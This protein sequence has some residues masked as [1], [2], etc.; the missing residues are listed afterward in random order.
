MVTWNDW[1]SLFCNYRRNCFLVCV[2]SIHQFE[3]T[4][5]LSYT[6]ETGEVSFSVTSD[7]QYC[8]SVENL[9]QTDAALSITYSLVSRLD[10]L[11]NSVAPQ[12]ID[13]G[14]ATLI[15]VS[16]ND[17]SKFTPEEWDEILNQIEL[18]NISWEN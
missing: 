14:V 4:E 17:E 15:S 3:K 16:H 10:N 13:S 2:S 11:S 7:G 18:G 5:K 12:D 8:V 6:L 9:S 1:N